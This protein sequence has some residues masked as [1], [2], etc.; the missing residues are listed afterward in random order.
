MV[1]FNRGERVG[2]WEG[3]VRFFEK[4][5]DFTRYNQSLEPLWL[6]AFFSTVGAHRAFIWGKGTRQPPHIKGSGQR[7]TV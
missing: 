4:N 5:A 3:E 2:T 7:P 6:K 1:W